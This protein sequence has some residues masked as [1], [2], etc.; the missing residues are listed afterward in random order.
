[1]SQSGNCLGHGI[2]G[3]YQ[4]IALYMKIVLHAHIL[5]LIYDDME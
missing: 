4:R 2:D 1:M 3:L 5:E